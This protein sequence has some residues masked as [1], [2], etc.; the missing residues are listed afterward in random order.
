MG[1]QVRFDLPPSKDVIRGLGI[2]AVRNAQIANRIVI[3][4]DRRR[5]DVHICEHGQKDLL[6]G[7]DQRHISHAKIFALQLNIGMTFTKADV[8]D[9]DLLT[10]PPV[11]TIAKRRL[12]RRLEV[13]SYFGSRCRV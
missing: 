9:Y 2:H 10:D 3:Q 1:A 4:A 12:Q 13:D 5:L 7:G 11:A 6:T 8:Y